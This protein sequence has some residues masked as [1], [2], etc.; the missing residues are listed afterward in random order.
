MPTIQDKTIL[1]AQSPS[2]VFLFKEGIFYM[3]SNPGAYLMRRKN[4][5]VKGTK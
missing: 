4:Y 5:K 3:A 1:L 2:K